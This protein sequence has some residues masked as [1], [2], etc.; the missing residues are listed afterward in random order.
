ML[1]GVIYESWK[2][3]IDRQWTE[4]NATYRKGYI[5]ILSTVGDASSARHEVRHP[6]A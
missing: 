5:K 6:K 3:G 4:Y 2:D 1:H